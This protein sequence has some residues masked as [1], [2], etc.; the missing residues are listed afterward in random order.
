[1]G[2]K[3]KK[4]SQTLRIDYKGNVLLTLPPQ[5]NVYSYTTTAQLTS[6]F[7]SFRGLSAPILN[8]NSV[9]NFYMMIT[10][11]VVQHFQEVMTP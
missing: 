9:R 10:G 1:M 4:S 6:Y 8:K 3:E 5:F 11:V 7:S 2:S